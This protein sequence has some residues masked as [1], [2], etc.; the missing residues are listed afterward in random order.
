L[1]LKQERERERER[2][3][4]VRSKAAAEAELSLYFPRPALRSEARKEIA[5]T[6]PSPRC[7]PPLATGA[8][9]TASRGPAEMLG[10][11]PEGRGGASSS[12]AAGEAPGR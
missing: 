9:A 5:P 10:V 1:Y 6:G 12:A 3:R 4:E 7:A 8:A 11:E 2:E